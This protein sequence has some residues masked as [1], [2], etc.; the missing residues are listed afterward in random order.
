MSW[1]SEQRAFRKS[2]E[3][4]AEPTITTA[5]VRRWSVYDPD[6]PRTARQFLF[7]SS[8]ET[9][10]WVEHLGVY[11]LDPAPDTEP[12]AVVA[13]A[14]HD[15]KQLPQA[16]EVVLLADPDN[17]AMFAILTPDNDALWPLGPP[18]SATE[19]DPRWD[20]DLAAD[21]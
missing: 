18:R 11:P 17:A 10:G 6:A 2:I 5:L 21:D 8:T 4:G 15:A 1:K 12:Y 7:R 3:G 13:L 20:Q 16:G 14:V 9:D 19:H